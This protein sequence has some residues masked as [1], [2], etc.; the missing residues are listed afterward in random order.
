MVIR[1]DT[2]CPR[3][4]KENCVFDREMYCTDCKIKAFVKTRVKT[5]LH[6]RRMAAE[7]A[8]LKPAILHKLHNDMLEEILKEEKESEEKLE[9]TQ[10]NNTGG[11]KKNGI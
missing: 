7:V 8:K 5:N 4:K 10:L 3:C 2:T 9:K 6:N 1:F 11:I